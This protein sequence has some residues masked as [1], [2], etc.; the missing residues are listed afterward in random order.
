MPFARLASTSRLAVV[1]VLG[2]AFTLTCF[3]QE[4]PNKPTPQNT[5]ETKP[6]PALNFS[7]AASHFPNPI[8]PY[9]AA[10]CR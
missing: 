1:A 6:V 7:K 9:T 4:P 5:P 8:A 3:A 10:A 2:C